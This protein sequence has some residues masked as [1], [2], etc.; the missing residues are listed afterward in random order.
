MTTAPARPAAAPTLPLARPYAAVAPVLVRA[1]LLPRDHLDRVRSAPGWDPLHLA[2]DPDVALAVEVASPAAAAGLAAHAAGTLDARRRGRLAGTLL[3][4]TARMCT[5]TVP[6]GLFSGVGAAPVVERTDL[7]LEERALARARV[8]VDAGWLLR[9]VQRLEGSDRRRSVPLRTND[10]VRRRGDRLVLA[11][12]D[13]HG[14]GRRRST[15]VRATEVV[16]AAV[17]RAADGATWDELV[18]AVLAAAPGASPEQ[19]DA[20]VDQLRDLT[21]L[22]GELRPSMTAAHPEHELLAALARCPGLGAERELLGEVCRLTEAASRPGGCT[23]E[24]LRDLVAAQAALLPPAAGSEGCTYQVDAALALDGGVGRDVLDAAEEAAALLSVL[25]LRPPRPPHL[26]DHHSAFVERYGMQAEVPVLEVLDPE[27]GLGPPAGYTQP[28]TSFVLPAA[29]PD[30]RSALTSSLVALAAD[31]LRRGED[32]L[33]LTDELTAALLGAASGG[34]EGPGPLR[35]T[36]DLFAHLVAASP[37]DVADGRWLLICPTGLVTDAGRSAGRFADLLPE[38]ARAQLAD[39]ARAEEALLPGTRHVDLRYLP[40]DGRAANVAVHPAVRGAETT[41]NVARGPAATSVPLAD[42]V[43]GAVA[44]RYYLR[45]RRTGEEL[46]FVQGHL[47]VPDGAPNVVRFLLEASDDGFALHGELDWGHLSAAP[48]LPRLQRGRV[49]LAPRRWRLTARR[50]GAPTDRATAGRLDEEAVRL[51]VEAWR[52]DMGAP[53]VVVLVQGDSRLPLDLGHAAQRRELLDEVVRAAATGT[54]AVLE[55]DLTGEGHL[56]LRDGRGRRHVQELVVPLVARTAALVERPSAPAAPSAGLPARGRAPAPRRSLPGHGWTTLKLYS[57]LE[58]H[59]DV[60]VEHL[61]ALLAALGTEGLERWYF[62]RYCDPYPH[63]RLRL[64]LPGARAVDAG[65]AL[66]TALDWAAD[67]VAAGRAHDVV[68]GSYDREVER[69][70][71]PEMLAAAERAF[72]AGS[73]TALSLL[74]ARRELRRA[75]LDPDDDVVGVLLLQDLSA[76]WGRD[77]LLTPRPFP[78]GGVDDAARQRHREVLPVLAPLLDPSLPPGPPA[79]AS[80]AGV[81]RGL[82]DEA[83]APA[84]NTYAEVGAT[85]R[86]LQSEGRLWSSDGH[87][88]AAVQ[89]MLLNRCTGVDVLAEER[90]HALWRLSTAAVRRRRA[91]RAPGGTARPPAARDA[92]DRKSVV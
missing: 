39:L 58:Q 56:W 67:V 69:Y 73:L 27:S 29:S 85:S 42:V 20:L 43:V 90:A 82:L 87:V 5:R 74:T 65:P 64:R 35:P 34:D 81:L 12:S 86:R 44:D 80:G 48:F 49:V 16:L 62:L 76:A 68:L 79:A 24:A 66:G 52:R 26:R 11:V 10:H 78:T 36:A 59:D 17:S 8:R 1:P 83:A 4:Y 60:L 92:A 9:L 28:S 55:E 19:A 33:Q 40:G 77:P 84:R 46:R 21:L 32:V 38:E 51:L 2:D 30:E 63:L 6:Y 45:H 3:R 22:V 54:G 91:A 13:A 23:A 71:G 70:G 31:A 41:L 57:G 72:E 88:L 14:A 47:L 18:D 15:S 37:E 75:D 7:R 50:L 61:P 89:H 53:G 25:A